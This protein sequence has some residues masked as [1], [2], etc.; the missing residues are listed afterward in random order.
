M[1]GTSISLL[2]ITKSLAPLVVSTACATTVVLA[3]GRRLAGVEPPLLRLVAES[4]VFFG[5]YLG[6]LVA[7]GQ[8]A[9]YLNLLKELNVLPARLRRLAE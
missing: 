1:R 8:G 7:T 4:S 9:V 6:A 3:V 2:D 5:V